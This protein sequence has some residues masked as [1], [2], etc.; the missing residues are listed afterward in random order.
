MAGEDHELKRPTRPARE[1]DMAA[2]AAALRRLLRHEAHVKVETLAAAA[3][4]S[5]ANVSRYLRGQAFPSWEFVHAS[6]TVG[7]EQLNRNSDY[8]T[9]DIRSELRYWQTAWTHT[10]RI[11]HTPPPANTKPQPPP[12]NE[13]I[14]PPVD[15]ESDKGNIEA[16]KGWRRVRDAVFATAAGIAAAYTGTRLAMPKHG[17][18]R[19]HLVLHPGPPNHHN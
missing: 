4:M 19:H 6:V 15:P 16:D 13:S 18:T 10:E 8:I 17:H 1:L 14:T 5:N 9:V 3:K 2:F 7:L 11:Q 12:D